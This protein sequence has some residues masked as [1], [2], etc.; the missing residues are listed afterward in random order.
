MLIYIAPYELCSEKEGTDYI[1][2]REV[3]WVTNLTGASGTWPTIWTPL[4]YIW[5]FVTVSKPQASEPSQL[6]N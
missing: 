5:Y 4:N 2:I 6:G 1:A 3:H